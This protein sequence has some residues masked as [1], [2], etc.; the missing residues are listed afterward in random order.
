MFR[1]NGYCTFYIVYHEDTL[2]KYIYFSSAFQLLKYWHVSEKDTSELKLA[3][4][5]WRF[6]HSKVLPETM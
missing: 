2:E 5:G 1:E 3:V 6:C 4:N